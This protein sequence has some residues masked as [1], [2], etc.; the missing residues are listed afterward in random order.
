MTCKRGK[1]KNKSDNF[2]YICGIYTMNKQG[3]NITETIKQLYFKLGDQDKYWSPHKICVTC[4][5]NLTAWEK[6]LIR[7][8]SFAI[9]MIWI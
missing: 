9:P 4:S 8:M 5:S 7:N 3:R 6:G 2:C 1:C